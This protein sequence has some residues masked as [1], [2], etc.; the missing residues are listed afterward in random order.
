MNPNRLKPFFVLLLIL[1]YSI[2]SAQTLKQKERNLKA[3]SELYGY[4]RFFHPSD[5]V[6]KLNW[7]FFSLYGVHQVMSAQNDQEL[8]RELKAL[9]LPIAPS[10]IIDSIPILK[11]RALSEIIPEKPSEYKLVNWIHR[12]LALPNGSPFYKSQR[13]NRDAVELNYT[14][15]PLSTLKLDETINGRYELTVEVTGDIT[16][17]KQ[18][19]LF[20]AAFD[21]AE[22]LKN[23]SNTN[24]ITGKTI[25]YRF[26]GNLPEGEKS[27]N[28]TL[29]V[30]KYR[31]VKIN[32]P[33]IQVF[34][35]RGKIT[36]DFKAPLEASNAPLNI[37]LSIAED[38]RFYFTSPAS[39]SEIT[40]VKLGRKIYA[41]IP[42][43]LYATEIATYPKV[44]SMLLVA[45]QK[46]IKDYW[47]KKPKEYAQEARLANLVITLSVLKFAFPYW[48][49]TKTNP[50]K[51]F[52]FLFARTIKDNN[53][54]D[55]LESLRLMSAK[56]NDGHMGISYSG[57][58]RVEEKSV[59]IESEMI[60]DKIY[61][62]RVLDSSLKYIPVGSV[63]DSIDGESAQ[64]IF[65]SR[66]R[67][68]SGSP[69]WRS[70]KSL[71]GLFDGL[72]DSTKLVINNNGI[73]SA[74]KIP[75][76]SS[77]EEYRPVAMP[78][79]VPKDGQLSDNVYYFNLTGDS[80]MKN[81]NASLSRL[82]HAKSIIFDMRGYPK[83]NVS[84][85][86]GHLLQ[87]SEHTKWM[88]VP[89]L[90]PANNSKDF[91]SMGWNLGPKLPYFNGKI[92][93]LSDACAQSQSESILGYVKGLKLGTIIGKATSGTNGDV[94]TI[95][96]FDDFR[97]F[98]TGTKV[99]NADGTKSHYKG[100]IPDIVVRS[101][102]S[103]LKTGRDEVLD[104]A[105]VFAKN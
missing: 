42:G 89:K 51:L 27:I 97:V 100:I 96:L 23:K 102:P 7:F 98:F 76:L 69:Q 82:E 31:I 67:L 18:N 71:L 68:V 59:S 4:V 65:Y 50:E 99:T 57:S 46:R 55:F 81:I 90:S 5:E 95:N 38:K 26:Q 48:E 41:S 60:D 79:Y 1:T 53:S 8:I 44:D 17:C 39:I 77:A 66:F 40:S 45:F 54:Q 80:V 22:K 30:P 47:S 87:C 29:R 37:V 16:D 62:K 13:N 93:F 73:R 21:G 101:T 33:N 43:T 28:F 72:S 91:E 35:R 24:R 36:F 52:S 74:F 15:Y 78:G 19:N 32:K 88:H 84:A 103:G 34:S 61:V 92:I 25:R 56:L 70:Y 14:D 11:D 20:I 85:I 94:Q 9:M 49:D 2:G 6:T 86:F 83:E 12:G 10:V 64:K 3:F 58:D 75:R 104:K 105:L 63:I